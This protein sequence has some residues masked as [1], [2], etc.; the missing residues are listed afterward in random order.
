MKL[1][2]TISIFTLLFTLSLFSQEKGVEAHPVELG[3]TDNDV[4]QIDRNLH[5]TSYRVYFILILDEQGHKTSEYYKY[6]R[7][8]SE[9]KDEMRKKLKVTYSNKKYEIAM[10]YL[11]RDE[12]AYIYNGYMYGDYKPFLIRKMTNSTKDEAQ[13]RCNKQSKGLKGECLEIYVN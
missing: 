9:S 13:K 8:E 3:Q 11:K 7:P 4:Y 2:F 5:P 1:K 6:F 12:I 10:T